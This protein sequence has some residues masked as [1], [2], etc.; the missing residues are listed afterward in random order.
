MSNRRRVNISVDPHT[1]DQLRKLSQQHGFRNVCEIVTAFVHILL[2]RMA[3]KEQ[4][5]FDLPDDDDK[6]ITEMFDDLGHVY[7]TPCG[8]V[9]RRKHHKSL[10]DYGER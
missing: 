8:E 3:P 9:P 10:I 1:Y 6:Y 4:Q 7:R 2:D 5:R